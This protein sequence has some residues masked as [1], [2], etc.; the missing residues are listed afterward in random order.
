MVRYFSLIDF[1]IATFSTIRINLELLLMALGIDL[2]KVIQL[3]YYN[4]SDLSNAF[5]EIR[6]SLDLL[7]VILLIK[8]LHI[9]WIIR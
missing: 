2:F 3:I 4:S 9:F 8:V 6:N 1:I 5:V 7:K